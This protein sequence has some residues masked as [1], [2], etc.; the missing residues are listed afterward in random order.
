[1]DKKN[2]AVMTEE[3]WQNLRLQLK[4]LVDIYCDM[5]DDIIRIKTSLKSIIKHLHKTECE[6]GKKKKNEKKP[7]H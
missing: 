5:N 6:S 2:H 4:T 3:S 7:T 1:M